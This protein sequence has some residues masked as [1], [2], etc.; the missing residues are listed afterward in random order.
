MG[1]KGVETSD[2]KAQLDPVEV[3]ERRKREQSAVFAK[4]RV[5]QG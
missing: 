3:N 4:N 1:L 5:A 2:C